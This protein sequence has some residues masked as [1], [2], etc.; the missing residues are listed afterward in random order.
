[1]NIVVAPMNV[2]LDKEFFV[3]QV[4]NEISDEWEWISVGNGPFI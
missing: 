3:G 4:V 1:M 2:E